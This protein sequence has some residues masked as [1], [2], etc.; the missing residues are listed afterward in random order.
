MI[1]CCEQSRY[2]DLYRY[3]TR[4]IGVANKLV[5]SD[6]E[7]GFVYRAHLAVSN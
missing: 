1:S 4:L 5:S 6:M 3:L 2:C 7:L